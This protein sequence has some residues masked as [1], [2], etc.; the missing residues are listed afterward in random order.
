MDSTL[1]LIIILT[2][3]ALLTL[4]IFFLTKKN[5]KRNTIIITVV[6]GIIFVLS[7]PAYITI[8]WG[9]ANA[10]KDIETN[11]INEAENLLKD[12]FG[13]LS[14]NVISIRGWSCEIVIDYK[15]EAD[16][17]NYKAIKSRLEKILNNGLSDKIIEFCKQKFKSSLV[18]KKDKFTLVIRNSKEILYNENF[19]IY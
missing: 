11:D 8:S 14:M 12:E 13:E 2:E 18:P 3:I 17:E 10:S 4:T 7:L 6:A 1:L 9:F 16:N 15:K 19:T 5:A